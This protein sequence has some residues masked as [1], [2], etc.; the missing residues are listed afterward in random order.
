MGRL[1]YCLLNP[2]YG[3]GFN[4]AENDFQGEQST[5]L[6]SQ[7]W[8]KQESIILVASQQWEESWRNKCISIWKEEKL[9]LFEM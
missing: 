6:D 2:G 5:Q 1:W 3:F 4:S 7:D 9:V 8:L